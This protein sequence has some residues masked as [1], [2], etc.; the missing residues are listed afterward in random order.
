MATA[1]SSAT[2]TTTVT[3]PVRHAHGKTLDSKIKLA[4]HFVDDLERDIY[5]TLVDM[6]VTM[7]E[8]FKAKI[9]DLDVHMNILR[10]KN[11]R[12]QTQYDHIQIIVIFLS[13]MLTVFEGVKGTVFADVVGGGA[14]FLNVVPMLLSS[15]TTMIAA[16]VKFLNFQVVLQDQKSAI[17][18]SIYIIT[19]LKKLVERV[20]HGTSIAELETIRRHYLDDDFDEYT[21][22]L[23][24]IAR[25]L[26]YK[27]HVKY[28]KQ[29]DKL[30]LENRVE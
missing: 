22:A 11:D 2:T 10:L 27:D 17:D 13:T 12:Y 5:D 24:Q 3:K 8:N 19:G 1:T 26:S 18:R 7:N 28:G 6:K 16:I 20:A 9:E 30:R 21:T 23:Q 25:L 29:F 14:A 4:E 15:V